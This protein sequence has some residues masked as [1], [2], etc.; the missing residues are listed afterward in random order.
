MNTVILAIDPKRTGG[1][2]EI[3]IKANW[4]GQWLAV[5]RELDRNHIGQVNPKAGYQI[6]HKLTGRM[7]RCFPHRKLAEVKR[8]AQALE[9][10]T[11]DNIWDFTDPK[12]ASISDLGAKVGAVMEQIA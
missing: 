2:A 1:V 4:T 11:P 3:S 6:T 7:V 5:H 12:Q 9:Q 10:I 8:I